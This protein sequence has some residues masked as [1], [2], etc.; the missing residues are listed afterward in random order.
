MVNYQ[1]DFIPRDSFLG[2]SAGYSP[3]PF[4]DMHI[5]FK[6]GSSQILMRPKFGPQGLETPDLQQNLQGGSF[7]R[8]DAYRKREDQFF[9]SDPEDIVDVQVAK[10]FKA[11]PDIYIKT[12]LTR[13]R[14]GLY[15]MFGRQIEVEWVEG[16][17][18]K[19]ALMVKD[20][21]M[22]QP[23]GDYLDQKDTTAEYNGSVFKAK[24]NLQSIPQDARM[25][26]NDNDYKYSRMDAMKVAKEQAIVREVAATVQVK[27]G[28]APQ[29]DRLMMRYEKNMDRKLGKGEC[30][31][32]GKGQAM[33]SQWEIPQN[34]WGSPMPNSVRITPPG[35][36]SARRP[37]PR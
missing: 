35:S 32:S 23:F 14:P 2:T 3:S 17:R 20:G 26:F 10:F 15:S 5:P 11:F 25:T 24:N 28:Q 8:S 34:S 1:R 30:K 7:L 19:G 9:I 6:D 36:Q 18:G 31:G 33:S 22:R 16:R 27:Q 4:S 12:R 13:M 21:P 37:P 29:V